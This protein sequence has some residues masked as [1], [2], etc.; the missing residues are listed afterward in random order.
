MKVLRKSCSRC[1]GDLSLVDD[2]GDTYY[3]CVQCGHVV[4][5]LGAAQRPVITAAQFGEA[6]ELQSGRR[7]A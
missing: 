3:S 1:Q 2:V 5:Q 4:Y 6:P 7:A